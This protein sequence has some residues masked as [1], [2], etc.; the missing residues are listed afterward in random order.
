[1]DVPGSG[2]IP[3]TDPPDYPM[4]EPEFQEISTVPVGTDPLSANANLALETLMHYGGT[5]PS[6]LAG[7]TE[8]GLRDVIRRRGAG[9][10]ETTP[11]GEDVQSTLQ[12]LIA[13]GGAIPEDQQRRAMEI[14]AARSPLDML[15][16]A[17]MEQGQAAL[18]SRNLLGQGPEMDYMQRLE[19]GLAPM[20]AQAGQQIQLA[21]R[22]A[23]DA[24][25]QQALE[26]GQRMAQQ[27]D[28]MQEERL[29]NAMTLATGMSQEQSRNLLNAVQTTTDRQQ[30]LGDMAMKSLDQNMEWN[31]FLAEFGLKRD[32][33]LELIQTGRLNQLVP[34]IELYLKA[35]LEARMGY[36]PSTQEARHVLDEV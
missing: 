28:L 27:S 30:M 2:V 8:Q 25:Y 16:Q 23:A 36:I 1:M 17:Q 9:A 20:Y 24:R 15:R 35:A 3:A 22:A 26:S 33:A 7:E 13:S 31:K 32:Q 18:A 14:E 5:V 10:L 6:Y 34:L 12:D 19:Q 21:E 4:V 11:L 29:S